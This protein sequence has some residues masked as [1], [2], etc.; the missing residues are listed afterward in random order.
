[1]KRLAI[2]GSTGSIGVST[3]KLVESLSERFEVAAM[4]AGTNLERLELQIRQFRPELVAVRDAELAEALVQRVGSA[5]EVVS[6]PAGLERVAQHPDVDLVVGGIV[7]AAGLRPVWA[8]VD[9]GRDVALAN[10]EALVVAG[11][12][13]TRRAA[14]TGALILPVD[15]EHNALHQ[16]LRGEQPGEVRNLWLTASGGP[17]RGRTKQELEQVTP[18]QALRHPTWKM[19][20]KI[21]IDSATL[22]N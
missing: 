5:C 7:G 9:I 17:F 8:A 6:G 12:H 21:T 15:S 14:E 1:M 10:K 22:M 11:E 19:G 18:E 13:M 16:C 20:P 2:L 3:L 4:A